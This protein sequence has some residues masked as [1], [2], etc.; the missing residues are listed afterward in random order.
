MYSFTRSIQ[1]GVTITDVVGNACTVATLSCV[2]PAPTTVRSV[3]NG[4]GVK[5]VIRDAA[6]GEDTIGP[7]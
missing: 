1:G 6:G 4:C 3:A 7:L 5:G 2:V